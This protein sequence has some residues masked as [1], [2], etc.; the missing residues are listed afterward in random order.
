MNFFRPALLAVSVAVAL[1]GCG[2]GGSDSIVP[3]QTAVSSAAQ[4]Q[5]GGFSAG[6]SVA[7]YRPDGTTLATGTTDASGRA[8]VD[9]GTYTGPFIVKVSGGP[10]VTY[11]DESDGTNKALGAGASLIALVRGSA[12][13]LNSVGVTPL[14]HAAAVLAGVSATNP[15]LGNRTATDID[16]VNGQIAAL[17]GLPVGFDITRPPVSITLG[18]TALTGNNDASTYAAVLA[19]LAISARNNGLDPAAGAAQLAA[20]L[21]TVTPGQANTALAALLGDIRTLLAGGSVGGITLGSRVSFA[22][23]VLEKLAEIASFVIVSGRVPLPSEV[24]D[25]VKPPCATGATGGTGGTGGT[26]AS[27]GSGLG[28]VTIACQS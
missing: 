1:V 14:T 13:G 2:G 15:S 23:G 16:T 26:G 3:A 19:A 22:P 24:S 21:G 6:A 18:N 17:F 25:R 28:S 12:G 5:L 27:G 10:G 11:Y 4:P 7:Y 9:L 8:T 20:T